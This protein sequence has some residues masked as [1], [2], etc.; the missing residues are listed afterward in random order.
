M[1]TFDS[2]L[3]NSALPGGPG[4]VAG[5]GAVSAANIIYGAL[6]LLTVL[7]PGMKASPEAM[8]D[9]LVALNQLLEMWS[10]QRLTIHAFPRS[11]Y[12]LTAGKTSYSIGEDD[13]PADYDEL[14]PIRIERAGYITALATDETPID[15]LSLEDWTAGR[16]GV[17]FDAAVPTA[18]L[19]IRPAPKDGDQLA[20]YT[21]KRLESFSAL[22]DTHLLPPGYALALRYNLAD[23]MAPD[24]IFGAKIP[25]VLLDKIERK[26]VQYK[27]H[28]KSFNAAPAF[29]LKCDDA[30]LFDSRV[31]WR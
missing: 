5:T 17:Y 1:S 7:R 25:N 16:D 22:D 21:W 3:W 23:E 4:S 29:I 20:L 30:L 10:L 19:Q 24:F 8:E 12:T 14:R 6:R 26:A 15:V 9:G 18:T 28:I 2:E 11:L 27:A 13:P 31:G